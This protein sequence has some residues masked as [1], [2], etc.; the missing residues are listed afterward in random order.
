MTDTH[1]GSA[2]KE[3]RTQVAN[4]IEA[5]QG[6]LR[7][8]VI[9]L[10]HVEAVLRLFDPNVELAALFARK[11]APVSYDA[12]GDT[13]RIILETLRTAITPI[14]TAAVRGRDEGA[15]PTDDKGLCRLMMKRTVANLKHWSVKRGLIWSMPG[16]GQ[17]LFGKMSGNPTGIY[18][19]YE[20]QMTGNPRKPC[21]FSTTLSPHIGPMTIRHRPHELTGPYNSR[22]FNPTIIQSALAWVSGAIGDGL[23]PE[24]RQTAR[25]TQYDL[26]K[27][28]AMNGA[29]LKG[30]MRPVSIRPEIPKAD[31][32]DEISPEAFEKLKE[33]VKPIGA[34]KKTRIS[35]FDWP[36]HK[37]G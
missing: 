34:A 6:E 33:A 4:Q 14:T 11:V 29:R 23:G 10:D 2:H 1:G 21:L 31:Y 13:G 5:L 32:Q 35:G 19:E 15:R 37:Q 26:C 28:P 25:V 36:F 16:P 3:K 30:G 24:H 20:W 27:E 18:A 12:K 8:A 22:Q 17:Q 9:E 7:Q